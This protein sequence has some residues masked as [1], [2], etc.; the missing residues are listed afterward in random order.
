MVSLSQNNLQHFNL[1]NAL[2]SFELKI[3]S[4]QLVFL[5]HVKMGKSQKVFLIWPHPQKNELK[6]QP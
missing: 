1:K 2:W 6:H 3:N 5:I 4:V